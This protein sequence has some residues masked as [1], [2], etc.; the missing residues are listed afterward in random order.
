MSAC[1]FLGYLHVKGYFSA[2]ACIV[3]T[4]ERCPTGQRRTA[5]GRTIRPSIKLKL[6]PMSTRCSWDDSICKSVLVNG[7]WCIRTYLSIRKNSTIWINFIHSRWRV[8]LCCLTLEDSTLH[9]S[10]ILDIENIIHSRLYVSMFK[11]HSMP[12]ELSNKLKQNSI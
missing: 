11:R 6:L 8:L 5:H 4:L 1:H 7:Y 9:H 12:V 3:V 10:A 2:G